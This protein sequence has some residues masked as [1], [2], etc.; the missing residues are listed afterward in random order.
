MF[1]DE[2]AFDVAPRRCQFV[3]RGRGSSLTV[4]HT[5]ASRPFLQ[6]VMVWG[7]FDYNGCGPLVPVIG[8]MNATKYRDVLESN[9]LPF[10]AENYP[11]NDYILQHDNAPC[12][13]AIF[14]RNFLNTNGIHTIDWPPYSPDLAPIENLWAIV[15][16]KVHE[17]TITTRNVLLSRLDDI[18]RN[19]EDVRTACKALVDSMPRRVRACVVSK[20]GPIKY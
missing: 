8:T 11:S 1:S 14:V 15:K 4:S 20:G 9:L 16:R 7:C 2:S 12:H 13:K 19:D 17:H 3:R 10:V 5:V 18:W 6:K